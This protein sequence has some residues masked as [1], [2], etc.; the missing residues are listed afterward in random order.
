MQDPDK[1]LVRS[2]VLQ[3]EV[4]KK[5]KINNQESLQTS[6]IDDATQTILDTMD[7]MI[8]NA[9]SSAVSGGG[10]DFGG[11]GASG[12]YSTDSGGGDSGGS[13]E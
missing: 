10:G 9:T 12:D 7:A 4:K 6:F 2:D 5:K 11:G 3:Q 1:P 8:S 13:G